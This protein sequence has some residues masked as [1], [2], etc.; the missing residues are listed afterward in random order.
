MKLITIRSQILGIIDNWKE[1]YPNKK[2]KLGQGNESGACPQKC[3]ECGNFFDEVVAFNV[4][5]YAPDMYCKEC[6]KKAIKLF[7]SKK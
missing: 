1:Q 4:D 3:S 2:D 6:L 5:N 7:E